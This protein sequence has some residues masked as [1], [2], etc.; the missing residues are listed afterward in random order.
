VALALDL[1]AS[2]EIAARLGHGRVQIANVYA[3]RERW[4][5]NVRSKRGFH[6][7]VHVAVLDDLMEALLDSSRKVYLVHG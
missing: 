4:R 3:P 1:Q 2:L 6:A 5:C 7:G